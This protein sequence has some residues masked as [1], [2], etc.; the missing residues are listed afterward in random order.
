MSTTR[1]SYTLFTPQTPPLEAHHQTQRTSPGPRGATNGP[2]GIHQGMDLSHSLHHHERPFAPALDAAE[3]LVR[4][5]GLQKNALFLNLSYIICPEPVLVNDRFLSK[6]GAQKT[7]PAPLR[8]RPT[9]PRLL[10][11]GRYRRCAKRHSFLS[12][13]CLSRACLGKM[14]QLIYKWRKKWRF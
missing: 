8:S 13:P 14:M 11:W 12:F 9:L 5:E 4:A 7:F 10:Y 3:S 6:T 2:I 1:L